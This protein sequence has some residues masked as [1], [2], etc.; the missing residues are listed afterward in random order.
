MKSKIIL[1]TGAT[2]GIGKATAIALAK[3]GHTIIVHGRSR[4][5][6][7][8]VRKQIQTETGNNQIEILIADLLSLMDVR[9]AVAEFKEKHGRLDVLINN[10]I[11]TFFM[12]TYGL[13]THPDSGKGIFEVNDAGTKGIVN[14]LTELLRKS[15]S[16]RIVNV[17]WT[18]STRTGTNQ[19]AQTFFH[20]RLPDLQPAIELM[21]LQTAH[22]VNKPR[23]TNFKIDTIVTSIT[24]GIDPHDH[25]VI[26]KVKNESIDIIKYALTGK[27]DLGSI[28][29]SL[30]IGGEDS[31]CAAV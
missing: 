28:A 5:K 16:P 6:A 12:S 26:Q 15:L 14:K 10:T 30:D 17:I 31:T 18:S 11:D 3:K 22:V 21:R 27:K 20:H 13:S 24:T 19:S 4:E 9:R 25:Q 23:K 8:N 7:E 2:D 1:I 29:V